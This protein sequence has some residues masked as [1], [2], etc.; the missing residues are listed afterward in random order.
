MYGSGQPY[1]SGIFGRE[2]TRYTVIYGVY[3]RFWPTLFLTQLLKNDMYVGIL[4]TNIDIPVTNKQ[5]PR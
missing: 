4:M 1:I 2:I 5:R 3:I